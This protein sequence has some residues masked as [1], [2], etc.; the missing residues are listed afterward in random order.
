MWLNFDGIFSKMIKDLVIP[1]CGNVTVSC[2]SVEH[3]VYMSPGHKRQPF[4]CN[5]FR[6]GQVTYISDV[7]KMPP[8][9]LSV[10]DG[11]QLL[12]LDALRYQPHTSHFSIGE[13]IS[14]VH[15]RSAPLPRAF[16]IGFSHVIDH[17]DLEKELQ[18]LNRSSNCCQILPGYDGLQIYV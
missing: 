18:E 11:T 4:M 6:I 7:S 15:T 8:H 14:F 5:A 10:I 17:Y 2:F 16:L 9:A 12:I 1:S 13:A 3:G